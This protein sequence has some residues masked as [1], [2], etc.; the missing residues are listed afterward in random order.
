MSLKPFICLLSVKK[1]FLL[2]HG[3]IYTQ[4][5]IHISDYL[6]VTMHSHLSPIF[7]VW[8]HSDGANNA[9]ITFYP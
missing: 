8:P 6:L 9:K 3:I 5:Y 4:D 1:F 2:L 7:C